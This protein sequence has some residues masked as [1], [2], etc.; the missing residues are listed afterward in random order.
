MVQGSTDVRRASV[1]RITGAVPTS[2]A[3]A[4]G[5]R[6]A[7]TNSA[8]TGK[9]KAE[10]KIL[11]VARKGTPLQEF[12][13]EGQ[14]ESLSND[15]IRSVL[16]DATGKPPGALNDLLLRMMERECPDAVL[17]RG[18]EVLSAVQPPRARTP[19]FFDH[20]V[21]YEFGASSPLRAKLALMRYCICYSEVAESALRAAGVGRVKMTTGPRIPYLG[22]PLPEELTVGVLKTSADAAQ[23]LASVVAMKERHARNY[24]IV[25]SMKMLGVDC[26]PSDI[27][28]AEASTVLVAPTDFGDVGQPHEGAAL[29]LAFGRTL[30]T[31]RTSGMCQ[32]NFP[33]GTF[34]QVVKYSPGSYASGVEALLNGNIRKLLEW[35][36]EDRT[37][38][39]PVP[40]IIRKGLEK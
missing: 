8:E 12:V 9:A 32:V 34:V 4:R 29:A 38:A 10:I 21:P 37:F 26:L 5:P 33:T 11:E 24:R 19:F 35:V 30:I 1:R 28:V 36:S 17:L 40:G 15:G 18:G 2:E 6:E 23:T 39:D 25:S 14:R 31:T 3:P 13:R 27:D 16:L 20:C 7:H 22:L